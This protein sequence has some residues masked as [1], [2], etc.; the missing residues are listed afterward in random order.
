[1]FTTFGQVS[2]SPAAKA[3]GKAASDPAAAGGKSKKRLSKR[4]TTAAKSDAAQ[5][6]TVGQPAE[7]TAQL[8]PAADP[9]VS[10]PPEPAQAEADGQKHHTAQDSPTA[11]GTDVT[12]T[13]F[14]TFCKI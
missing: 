10:Q 11:K 7:S 13:V 3:D 1:L 12:K 9:A 4:D 8:S 2:V 5:S 6:A 14:F